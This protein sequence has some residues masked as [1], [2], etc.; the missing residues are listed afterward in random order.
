V[1]RSHRR[2]LWL[3]GLAIFFEGYG[4]T[5]V[6]VTLSY[7]GRDL[8]ATPEQLSYALALISIGSLGV[9][10]LG[11]VS[12]RIGRRR[13]LLASV[14]LLGLFGA[15]SALARTLGALVLWQGAARMFQEGALFA[16][17]VIAAEEMPAERRG[18]AQGLL[19]TMNAA[20]AGFAAFLLAAIEWWPGGW[21]GLC[22]VSLVPVVFLPFFRRALPESRRWLARSEPA[23]QLPP[24]AYRGRM[25]AALSVSFLAMSYDVA[26]FAFATYVPVTRYGWSAGAVSAM[27]IFAGGLGLPGWWLGGELADRRGRRSAAALCFVGLSVAEV[28]F[29]LGGPSALWPAFAAMVFFQ[30]G[31]MTVVRSW[32]TELFPTSFRGAAAAWLAAA[33]MLGGMCGLAL[34]G[35]LAP[36]VGGIHVALAIIAGSGVLAAIAA[37]VWLPETRGRE[38]EAIAPE[39]AST[40]P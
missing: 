27:F 36:L 10:A 20:G 2:L 39:L 26:G 14:A 24:P 1:D 7:I 6:N 23:L 21:R 33:G 28:G 13:L 9:I 4:R 37:Y 35:A 18:A 12:D 22:L 19:G 29:Y 17:A 16:A 5:L 8:D 38:L 40:S 31:K 15:A 34:A 3:L 32:S 25:L 30:G 11:P